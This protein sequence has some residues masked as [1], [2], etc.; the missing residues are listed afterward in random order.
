MDFDPVHA[1]LKGGHKK[2]PLRI[3][4]A[5]QERYGIVKQLT[6]RNWE[7][8]VD[9]HGVIMNSVNNHIICLA[10]GFTK[11]MS[12]ST[13]IKTAHQTKIFYNSLLQGPQILHMA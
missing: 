13:P 8:T 10:T 5:Q 2:A 1:R 7:I 12:R 4:N 11:L 6:Y 9:H 3:I